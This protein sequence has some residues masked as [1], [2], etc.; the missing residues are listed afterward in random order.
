[1]TKKYFIFFQL[2]SFYYSFIYF[3]YFLYFRN[4]EC[5]AT[6]KGQDIEHEKT[7]FYKFL[8]SC[9]FLHIVY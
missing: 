1:M 8:T 6:Q 7:K 3:I 4:I 2:K 5:I 9:L